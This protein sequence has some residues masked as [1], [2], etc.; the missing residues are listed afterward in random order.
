MEQKHLG[1]HGDLV[2]QTRRSTISYEI[3]NYGTTWNQDNKF[4]DHGL[5]ITKS[6]KS[7]CH[8]T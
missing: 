6:T 3:P 2:Q 8:G 5:G 7:S 4:K 1:T